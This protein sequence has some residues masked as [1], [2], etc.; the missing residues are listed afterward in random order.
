ME[1]TTEIFE[2]ESSAAE[3]SSSGI[4]ADDETPVTYE[5]AK[6]LVLERVPYG[7]ES[8]IRI[9]LELEE[10]REIYDGYLICDSKKYE[11]EIDSATG[12]F[13]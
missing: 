12:I 6:S 2:T 7:K 13:L 3:T 4:I 9:T 11:F 8:D 5:K 1:T 10:G